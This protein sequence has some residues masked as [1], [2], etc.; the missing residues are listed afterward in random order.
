MVQL[1]ILN[2]GSIGLATAVSKGSKTVVPS[3]TL[4]AQERDSFGHPGQA[5]SNGMRISLPWKGDE[6]IIHLLAW[7]VLPS[8]W[9]GPKVTDGK[10]GL[11]GPI[12]S[13]NEI[14]SQVCL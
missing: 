1:I 3:S 6:W 11:S 2:V 10:E 4:K 13:E 5:F 8:L 14:P 9:N 12:L 7:N